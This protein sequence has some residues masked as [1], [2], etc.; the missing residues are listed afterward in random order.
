MLHALVDKLRQSFGGRGGQPTDPEYLTIKSHVLDRIAAVPVGQAPFFHL[1]IDELFPRPYFDALLAH[2]RELRTP[3]KMQARTQDNAAFVNRR[4]PLWDSP[5]PLVATFRA[6]WSDADIKRALFA[7][8][9]V[10]PKDALLGDIRIHEKEFEFVFCE[11]GRF[12]NI[13]VDIPPKYMSFVFY[14]PPGPLSEDEEKKNATVL[15]DRDLKPVHGARFRQNSVCIFVPHFYSY[16]GFSTTMD[17]DVLVMFMVNGPDQKRWHALLKER[18]DAAP[19]FDG[20][21]DLIEDKLK[22][23]PLIEYGSDPDRIARERAACRIN[24]PRGRVMID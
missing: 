19:R 22:R 8:F 9:Y 20:T 14:F 12:Q 13:H 3:D 5:N 21:L 18:R 15:Y 24:A 17:R 7:K 6:L 16:H 2:L 23:N 1:F 11:P 10:D 4:Y